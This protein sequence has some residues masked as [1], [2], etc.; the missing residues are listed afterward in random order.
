MKIKQFVVIANPEDFMRGDYSSCF[1]LFH[2]DKHLPDNWIVCGE[3]DVDIDVDTGAV[4]KQATDEID[5][6]MHVLQAAMIKLQN[7]KQDLLCIEGPK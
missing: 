1:T 2:S 5:R 6:E 3:I 7:R 4:L